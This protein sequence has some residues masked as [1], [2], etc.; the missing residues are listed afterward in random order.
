VP[1]EKRGRRGEKTVTEEIK[2]RQTTEHT[3]SGIESGQQADTGAA[4]R[5]GATENSRPGFNR[6][7][8]ENL[9]CHVEGQIEHWNRMA[10]RQSNPEAAHALWQMAEGLGY[11]LRL[12]YAFKP[13][14]E[15]LV[16]S[17]RIRHFLCYL[18]F[19]FRQPST[20]QL[21]NL[22]FKAAC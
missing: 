6:Y 19:S 9:L 15:E 1:R 14:F 16:A 18:W 10:D 17:G 22:F 2:P 5:N 3:T 11:A 8:F 12:L 20:V 4:S 21:T 7:I 13:E